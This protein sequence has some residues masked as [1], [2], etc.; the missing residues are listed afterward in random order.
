MTIRQLILSRLSQIDGS[1]PAAQ[2]TYQVTLVPWYLREDYR[3]EE[4]WEMVRGMRKRMGKN[5]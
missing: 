3:K 4:E 1:R 2:C 5:D